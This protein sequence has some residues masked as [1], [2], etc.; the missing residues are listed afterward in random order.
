[1]DSGHQEIALLF[2]Y[3]QKWVNGNSLKGLK[4]S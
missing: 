4:I 1:M 2:K 3:A